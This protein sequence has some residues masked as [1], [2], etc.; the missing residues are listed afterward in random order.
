MGRF[1]NLCEAVVNIPCTDKCQRCGDISKINQSKVDNKRDLLIAEYICDCGY[2]HE[3]A[4]K[5]NY[6]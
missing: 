1:V 3:N 4:I 6:I 5:I 2:I